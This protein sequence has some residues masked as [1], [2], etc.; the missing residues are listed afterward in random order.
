MV[1][2]WLYSSEIWRIRS[3][4]SSS[5]ISLRSKL[6]PLKSLIFT[7]QLV[8]AIAVTGAAAVLVRVGAVRR[9]KRAEP[10]H[11]H[12]L[13][14]GRREW[15]GRAGLLLRCRLPSCHRV[16]PPPRS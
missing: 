10:R 5:D 13:T 8:V 2:A 6:P 3:S 15:R 7:S 1:I 4:F 16:V 12:A 9:G 14:L 11:R